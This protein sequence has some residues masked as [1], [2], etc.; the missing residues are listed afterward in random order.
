MAVHFPTI[1][2]L[3]L[4]CI[5]DKSTA[6]CNRYLCV[7]AAINRQ[8]SEWG[9]AIYQLRARVSIQGAMTWIRREVK[10]HLRTPYRTPLPYPILGTPHHRGSEKS[11]RVKSRAVLEGL[12]LRRKTR[13]IPHPEENHQ[14]SQAQ[15][16]GR[17]VVIS[18]GDGGAETTAT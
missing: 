13:T 16:V 18:R 1:T 4:T 3:V 15:T 8:L 7:P 10:K 11:H 17:Q 9:Y 14:R 6:M 5:S 2:R 12:Q